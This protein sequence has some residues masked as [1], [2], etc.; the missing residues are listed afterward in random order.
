[1]N[2]SDILLVGCGGCGSSIVDAILDLDTRYESFFFNTSE[3]DIQTLHN[4]TQGVENYFIISTKNGV[5]RNKQLGTQLATRRRVSMFEILTKF[6]QKHIYIFTSL[7]GG[8]GSSITEVLLST[9]E[10]MTS[11]GLTFDKYINIVGVLPDLKSKDI[12]LLNT[13]N[14]WNTLM[15]FKCIT[16]T[17]FLNN[18]KASEDIVNRDF[19]KLFDSLF[20][21]PVANGKLFDE[22]NLTNLLTTKGNVYVY[23]LPSHCTSIE[24]AYNAA[25]TS[26][27]LASMHVGD[28][29]TVVTNS[30][31]KTKCS[32]IGVSLSEERYIVDDLLKHFHNIKEEYIGNNISGDNLLVLSGVTPPIDC[33]KAIQ[34]E[35]EHRSTNTVDDDFQFSVFK[36][37][38]IQSPS[39]QLKPI[40]T[41]QD[42][43]KT[44]LNLFKRRV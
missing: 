7:G 17:I 1:M 20:D 4:T 21:I 16:T 44:A 24:I 26:S 37:A 30:Q 19:A 22:G 10:D 25:K 13:L 27:V 9:I 29:N 12:L 2:R 15:S 34:D 8:S 39:I 41:Q 5:G 18:S 28:D 32:Y 14:S 36:G 6:N 23:N 31:V 33:I 43:I 35:L 38:T 3:S 40:A 11:Q 42:N